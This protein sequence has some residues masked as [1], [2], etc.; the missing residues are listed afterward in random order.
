MQIHLNAKLEAYS[1]APYYSDWVRDVSSNSTTEQVP[2]DFISY[3]RVKVPVGTDSDGNIVYEYKWKA[4][5]T[6]L[7]QS[8]GLSK[9]ESRVADNETDI[10][11]HN[12]WIK[13]I[14]LT[15]IGKSTLIFTDWNG[16]ITRIQLPTTSPDNE[17]IRQVTDKD[18][19]KVLRSMYGVDN[20]TIVIVPEYETVTD[21][22]GT[23]AGLK[24]KDK[25]RA[26]ALYTDFVQDRDLVVNNILSSDV[27]ARTL[28]NL[29][30]EINNLANDGVLIDPMPLSFVKQSVG[31]DDEA[32]WYKE[33]IVSTCLTNWCEECQEDIKE[34]TTVIYLGDG[35]LYKYI[36]GSWVKQ[37]VERP[38]QANNYVIGLV[39]SSD[40]V[41]KGNVDYNGHITINGL[42]DEV[43]RR[44]LLQDNTTKYDV[45]YTQTTDNKQSTKVITSEPI[46]DTVVSRTTDGRVKG[47]QAVDAEDFI[48]LAQLAS[49]L[50]TYDD[51]QLIDTTIGGD[52]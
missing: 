50:A 36:S 7:Q 15:D 34:G 3:V 41:W 45:V 47:M 33:K 16:Y 2:E 25:F 4:N 32:D 10:L 5:T 9:L 26:K 48:N 19:S 46:F 12:K 51:I 40:E 20:D 49:Y 14:S 17:T 28:Y 52:N 29:K 27:I 8:D 38:I 1:R 24:T 42:E 44:A 22:T 21:E 18:G 31:E 37:F 11:E 30:N 35:Y 13:N 43:N 39:R 6:V 23:H